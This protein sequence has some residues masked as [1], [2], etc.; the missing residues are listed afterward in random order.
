MA[1]IC[2]SSYKYTCVQAINKYCNTARTREFQQLAI[3]KHTPKAGPVLFTAFLKM[4]EPV[5]AKNFLLSTVA[6][7]LPSLLVQVS[8]TALLKKTQFL[9]LFYF[10][11]LKY[12]W[13]CSGYFISISAIKQ[14]YY[15]Y[16]YYFSSVLDL[17]SFCQS[18]VGLT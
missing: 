3:P 8:F 6:G 16:N 7:K 13:D 10:L 1:A 15:N 12:L 9:F 2:I 17:R 4:G 11:Q 14:Y 5:C 18:R